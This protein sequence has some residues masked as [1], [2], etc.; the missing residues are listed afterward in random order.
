MKRVFKK[1]LIA[2]DQSEASASAVSV[3]YSMAREMGAEVLLVHVVNH[4]SVG[5]IS[6]SRIKL[7]ATLRRKGRSLL[8]KM[9]AL[10][11]PGATVS[12]SLREGIPAEEILMNAADWGAQLLII[13]AYGQ[14]RLGNLLLGG[15]VEIVLRRALCPVV[16]V[17]DG[18]HEIPFVNAKKQQPEMRTNARSKHANRDGPWKN[19]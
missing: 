13:G 19:S 14:S 10:E 17:G 8:R 11:N 9:H 5:T 4:P 12:E 6:D 18:C 7:L 15:T 16:T 3:G 1:I 2:V